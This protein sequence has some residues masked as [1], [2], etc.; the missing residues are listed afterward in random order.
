MER[1]N[2]ESH[3]RFEEGWGGVERRVPLVL[4]QQPVEVI[5]PLFQHVPKILLKKHEESH[6]DEAMER[7][8]GSSAGRPDAA[9]DN[10]RPH[11][12]LARP[13]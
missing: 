10:Q 13:R 12:P 2:W 7:R 11:P 8:E 1:V 9:G 4:G 6:W 3:K 5:L